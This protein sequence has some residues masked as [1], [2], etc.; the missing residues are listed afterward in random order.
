VEEDKKE[1]Q[2]KN[3]REKREMVT[4]AILTPVLAP[5]LF[6]AKQL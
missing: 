2:A 6:Y 3:H 1:A 5:L 4:A